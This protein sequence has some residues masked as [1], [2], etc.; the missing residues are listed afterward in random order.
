MSG[1]PPIR[2]S[3]S[4]GRV[5]TAQPVTS[6]TKSYT[7]AYAWFPPRFGVVWSQ[8]QVWRE[9]AL[10]ER[11]SNYCGKVLNAFRHH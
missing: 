10:L 1:E 2:S 5:S 4:T 9:P 11:P 7:E 8:S 6:E 3:I